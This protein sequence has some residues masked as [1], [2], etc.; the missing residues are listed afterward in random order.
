MYEHVEVNG[1]DIVLL[2]GREVF[3]SENRFAEYETWADLL[4]YAETL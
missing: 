3:R 1:A 2:N 4:A